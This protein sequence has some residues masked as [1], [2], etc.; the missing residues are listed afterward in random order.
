MVFIKSTVWRSHLHLSPSHR[1]PHIIFRC[2]TQKTSFSIMRLILFCITYSIEKKVE[3]SNLFFFFAF[4]FHLKL[5][6]ILISWRMSL[7]RDHEGELA[8][9]GKK[10]FLHKCNCIEFWDHVE[11]VDYVLSVEICLESC[12]NVFR[13]YFVLFLK[14]FWDHSWIRLV[15]A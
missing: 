5:I 7:L 6:E 10:D 15:M 13:N 2:T 9:L 4:C 3:N 1:V 8:S 14:M 12:I 11:S